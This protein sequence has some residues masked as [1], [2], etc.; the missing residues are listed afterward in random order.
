MLLW[1]LHEIPHSRAGVRRDRVIRLILAVGY[2]F[3][4]LA[5]PRSELLNV[6]KALFSPGRTGQLLGILGA[7]FPQWVVRG[8][9]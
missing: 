6:Y 1:L 4:A 3:K 7:I 8:L 9:P 2:D 5:D